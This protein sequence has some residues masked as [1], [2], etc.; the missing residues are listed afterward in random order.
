M[1]MLDCLVKLAASAASLQGSATVQP[2]SVRSLHPCTAL[3][4]GHQE[5][6]A[7]IEQAVDTN[8]E[9]HYVRKSIKHKP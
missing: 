4:I 9:G 1:Q 2:S 7:G 3:H 5:A 8:K 6:C